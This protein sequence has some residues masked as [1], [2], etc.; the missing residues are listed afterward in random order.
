[1]KVSTP[2]PARH[3]S[4]TAKASEL[5]YLIFDRPDVARAEA[6]LVDF[7]LLVA[8]REPEISFLRGTGPAPCCYIIRKAGTASFVGFGLTVETE[9][10]LEALAALPE[11]GP[12]EP[13]TF[14]GGGQTVRLTCPSGFEVHAVFGRTPVEPLPHRTALQQNS[15]DSITRVN[16][17]QRLTVT[18][19]E[20]IKLGHVVLEVTDYQRTAAWYTRHF[21][22]IPTDIQIFKDGSPAVAFLRVDRGDTPVDHHTLVLAQGVVPRY[23]HSAYE[24]IDTDAVAMGQRVLRE[25]QWHH[26]WGMGRHL[27]GSQIFDY[28]S[29]PWGCHHEHYCDGDLFTADAPAGVHPVSRQAMSQ[30][31]PELPRSFTKPK[32]T[33]A[34]VRAVIHSLRT[35]PDLTFGKL[36]ALMKLFG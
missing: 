8:E 15:I 33:L 32:V 17:T 31:G 1:M 5:A 13:S 28:W 10:E 20:V 14:P 16:A 29:D 7:G 26:A 19:P 34:F 35:S 9:A 21:G 11:A 2:H 4:P 27:L 24:L 22:F 3:P 18:A 6:F 36:R 12:V 30:W 23:S 25:R